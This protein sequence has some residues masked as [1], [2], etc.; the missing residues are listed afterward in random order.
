MTRFS[1][2]ER[3]S[4][5]EALSPGA[6]KIE[7]IWC[8]EGPVCAGAFL[9]WFTRVS[10]TRFE[11]PV[12]LVGCWVPRCGAAL[13]GWPPLAVAPV[14]R[15]VSGGG[16]GGRRSDGSGG[17]LTSGRVLDLPTVLYLEMVQGWSLPGFAAKDP[18]RGDHRVHPPI[19]YL[20]GCVL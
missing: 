16:L 3:G 9:V 18:G 6:P 1:S 15:L 7:E 17:N 13:S 20:Q 14:T 5:G 12:K 2:E 19:T 4:I 10:L 8:E 11:Y